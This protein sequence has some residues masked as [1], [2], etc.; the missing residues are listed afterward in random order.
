VPHCL[1]LLGPFAMHAAF[2]RPDY[3][4]PS[5]PPSGYQ[6]T[7]RLPA[8]SSPGRRGRDGNQEVV[9]TFTIYRSPG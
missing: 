4:G 5:A 8:A 1:N 6:R 3:Y 7:T 2:P 9:P